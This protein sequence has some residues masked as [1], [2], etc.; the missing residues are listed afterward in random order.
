MDSVTKLMQISVDLIIMT[1]VGCWVNDTA[2]T[3][4][5][6]ANNVIRADTNNIDT[7]SDDMD[8]G[9]LS[10]ELGT[11]GTETRD[12]NTLQTPEKKKNY[13]DTKRFI[14]FTVIPIN[15]IMDNLPVVSMKWLVLNLTLTSLMIKTWTTFERLM[16][17]AA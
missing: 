15:G 16:A 6:T 17:P 5:H 12:R 13:G 3:C 7:D 11:T 10:R 1:R 2:S 9:R 14:N 4:V 8:Q